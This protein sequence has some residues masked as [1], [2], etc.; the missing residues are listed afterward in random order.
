MIRNFPKIWIFRKNCWH[1]WHRWHRWHRWHFPQKKGHLIGSTR[2]VLRIPNL[3][4][5]KFPK[6]GKKAGKKAELEAEKRRKWKRKW[7]RKSRQIGRSLLGL[8]QG[9]ATIFVRVPQCVFNCVSQTDFS[10]KEQ[11]QL[12]IAFR[13]PDVARG[14]ILPPFPFWSRCL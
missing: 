9:S 14:C 13:R 11:F 7:H 12:K 5:W 4:N 3:K 8:D 1:C 6:C 2:M 10:Q